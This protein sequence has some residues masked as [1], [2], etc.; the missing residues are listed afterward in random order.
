[1]QIE[2]ES[3][4]LE[5]IESDGIPSG[6]VNG[7]NKEKLYALIKAGTKFVVEDAVVCDPADLAGV[8]FIKSDKVV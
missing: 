8:P 4:V 1:M 5:T 2:K 3:R 6:W 7:D